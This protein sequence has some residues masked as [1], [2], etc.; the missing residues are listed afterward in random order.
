MEGQ[1]SVLAFNDVSKRYGLQM[2]VENLTFALHKGGVVGLIGPNGSGKSTLL[3]LAAGLLRPTTGVVTVNG[4]PV[5]GRA[6]Q[7]VSYLSDAPS[8]YSFFTVGE[9]LAH[10]TR[11]FA[12]FDFHKARE[13]TDFM[14]LH[15]DSRV[16]ALSKGNLG[17]LKLVVALSRR[18][19]LILLDEPLS[20]LDPMVRQSIIKG[21]ISFV[22]LEQQTVVLS[23][24]EVSEIEPLLDLVILIYQGIMQAIETVDT[25]RSTHQTSLVEWMSQ[26]VTKQFAK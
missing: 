8:L 7:G 3:K 4:E 23:S 6:R 17:R 11:T 20:G 14:Q 5:I 12:D 13:I 24:H 16:R 10:C 22:D 19:P 2:A 9:T 18:A 26:V 25:I 1:D 21:L 15:E